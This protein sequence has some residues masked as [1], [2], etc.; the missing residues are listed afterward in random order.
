MGDIE[1]LISQKMIP[2]E[3]VYLYYCESPELKKPH[4]M[5][6][7]SEPL[8]DYKILTNYAILQD[9]VK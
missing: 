9:N 3:K 7:S 2:W 5:V 8:K 1:Y 4:M 6:V